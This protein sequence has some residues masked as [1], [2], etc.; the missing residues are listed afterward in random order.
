MFNTQNSL[1]LNQHNGDDAPQD[2]KLKSVSSACVR[3][4]NYMVTFCR[5]FV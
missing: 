5:M 2:E 1:L 3:D 4:W